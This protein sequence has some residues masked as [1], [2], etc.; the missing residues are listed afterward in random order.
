MRLFGK[1][2]FERVHFLRYGLS[3]RFGGGCVWDS[4]SQFTDS[5]RIGTDTLLP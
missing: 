3:Q 2:W 5:L 4:D 1:S